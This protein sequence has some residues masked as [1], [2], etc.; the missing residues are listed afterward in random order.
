MVLPGI[1]IGAALAPL[2]A[3]GMAGVAASAA[4][5]LVN[6]AHQLGGSL[7]LGILVTVFAAASPNAGHRRPGAPSG[8]LTRCR[9]PTGLPLS[10]P[11][12]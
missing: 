9:A 7:G 4:S 8:A 11:M 1:G 6:V 10:R 2:T 5:D 12:S 3:A